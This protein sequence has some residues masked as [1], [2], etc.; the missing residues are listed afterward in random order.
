MGSSVEEL[1]SSKRIDYRSKGKDILIQCLNPEHDDNNP[2][3]RIDRETGIFNCFGCG[4][5]GDI[6]RY[7][8]RAGP[9]LN[10]LTRSVL[11]AIK[12]ATSYK[13]EALLFPADATFNVS[14]F[15]GLSNRLLAKYKAFKTSTLGLEDRVVFPISDTSGS[16][17]AYLGRHEYSD[18]SPKY[19]LYPKEVQ[20]PL[21]P[22]VNELEGLG[23]DL[24]IVEGLM[25]ALH[26][27]DNGLTNVTCAFGTKMLNMETAYELLHPFECFGIERVILMMDGDPAGR[28]AT[29]SIKKAIEYKT[30]IVVEVLELEDGVDPGDLSVQDIKNIKNHLNTL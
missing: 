1:L 5:S 2:S 10:K 28:A 8:N 14:D 25:D 15:R 4:Y 3:L 17:V 18:A 12:E 11:E 22:T 13:V 29:A 9:R 16:I 19:L 24:I 20:L 27:I 6:Y 30:D 7:F 23:S 26:L 21:F